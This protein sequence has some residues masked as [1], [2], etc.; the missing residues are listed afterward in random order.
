MGAQDR[1]IG[2]LIGRDVLASAALMCVGQS[3]QC[4]LAF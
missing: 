4:T 2:V 1:R 3:G